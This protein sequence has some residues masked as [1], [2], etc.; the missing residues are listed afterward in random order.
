MYA[1]S[2]KVLTAERRQW[3]VCVQPSLPDPNTFDRNPGVETPGYC[4]NVPPGHISIAFLKGI[5]SSPNDGG[6]VEVSLRSR[7]QHHAEAEVCVGVEPTR[8]KQGPR[9]RSTGLF[10]VVEGAAAHDFPSTRTGSRSCRIGLNSA[11]Q[12]AEPI[13]TPFHDVPF[14]VVQTPWIGK[15]LP[16]KVRRETAVRGVPRVIRQAC[17]VRIVSVA[18][19]RR[20]AGTRGAFPFSLRGKTILAAGGNAPRRDPGLIGSQWSANAALT[21]SSNTSAV[22]GF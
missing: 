16:D 20:R 8:G 13:L 2:D 19:P 18:E 1:T 15:L 12:E 10:G 6:G 11:R 14:H 21:S 5:T 22:N 4:R 3:P 7:D 9:G 17:V